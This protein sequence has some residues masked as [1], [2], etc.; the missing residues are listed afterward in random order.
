[1]IFPLERCLTH[2][3]TKYLVII[4]PL[5]LQWIEY[6]FVYF[7]QHNLPEKRRFSQAVS[8]DRKSAISKTHQ[9][10]FL[11]GVDDP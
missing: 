4:P 6:F 5:L 11:K 2:L 10:Q 8:E 3:R 7:F 9:V 1:M